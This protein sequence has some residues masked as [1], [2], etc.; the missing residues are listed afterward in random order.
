MFQEV[1]HMSVHDAMTDKA[2]VYRKH[3][4]KLYMLQVQLTVLQTLFT[5]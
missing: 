1:L 2:F 4:Y 5:V 3:T